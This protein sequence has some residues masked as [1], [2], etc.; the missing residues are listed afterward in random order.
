MSKESVEALL[1]K[2]R[3]EVFRKLQ[4][5]TEAF[6]N[7]IANYIMEEMARGNTTVDK[8]MVM[9]AISSFQGGAR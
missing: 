7:Y 2:E 8:W 9:D 4:A 6:A 5:E 1:G 3:V